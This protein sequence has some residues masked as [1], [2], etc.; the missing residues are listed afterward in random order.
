MD[1]RIEDVVVRKIVSASS[2]TSAIDATDLMEAKSTS[3]LIVIDE[4]KINGI[5][6]S[7]DVIQ[8][9]VA[10]G[11]D[12]K[13]VTIREIATRPVIMLKPEALLSEAIKIML[14]RKIKKI[15]LICEDDGKGGLVGLVSLSDIVEFHSELFST[16]WEQ[17][18]MIEPAAIVE[19]EF[20]VA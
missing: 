7:R 12:P 19:D 8:R 17:I 4:G 9:V 20:L 16:L 1:L 13:E 18:I 6:T 5:L 10:R 2:D 3:C 14:Q 15:P 11:L